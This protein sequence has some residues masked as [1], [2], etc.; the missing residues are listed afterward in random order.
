MILASCLRL[1]L[2]AGCLLLGA[3][4]AALQLATAEPPRL[5]QLTP[6]STFNN[7][8]P[9]VSGRLSV[10]VPTGADTYLLYFEDVF[11]FEGTQYFFEIG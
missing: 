2:L 10:E 5:Y 8:L 9:T 3:C 1:A 6:K 7:D 11:N 4:A